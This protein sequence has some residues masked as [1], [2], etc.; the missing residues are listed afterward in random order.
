MASDS[1]NIR[2]RCTTCEETYSAA[3][4][5]H[6]SVVIVPWDLLCVKCLQPLKVLNPK[7]RKMVGRQ[8][9]SE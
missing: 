7:L 5:R 8:S 6:G 9:T 2:A 3:I 1:I 4:P